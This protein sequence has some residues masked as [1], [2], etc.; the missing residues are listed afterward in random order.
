MITSTK[1]SGIK[2]MAIL[3]EIIQTAQ[4]SA[5]GLLYNSFD[6]DTKKYHKGT[7]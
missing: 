4:E 3:T 7:L 1:K 6:Y 2:N 5:T